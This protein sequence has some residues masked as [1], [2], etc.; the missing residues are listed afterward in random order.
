MRWPR[1]GQS[2]ARKTAACCTGGRDDHASEI[3]GVVQLGRHG[4]A[5]RG[6]PRPEPGAGQRRTRR[7]RRCLDKGL[8]GKSKATVDNYRSLAGKNLIP[9]IGALKLKELTARGLSGHSPTGHRRHRWHHPQLL[10]PRRM[11]AQDAA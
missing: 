3:N 1:L 5:G 4:R 8:K 10:A 7:R 11:A 6:L 9:Q 2:G